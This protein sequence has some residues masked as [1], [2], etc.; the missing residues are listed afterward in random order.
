[1]PSRSA[2]ARS[3]DAIGANLGV[4]VEND[5]LA[6]EQKRRPRCVAVEQ[7]VD[8]RDESLPEP[9]R[10]E[11]PLAVPV[12]VREDVDDFESRDRLARTRS[13]LVMRE[14]FCAARGGAAS[15]VA[16]MPERS[17]GPSAVPY[18]SSTGDA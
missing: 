4:V 9:A 5:G 11:V 13:W 7:L 10:R 17:E 18:V 14:E 6:V 16:V 1:M 3:R 2:S 15:G 12:R 8:Q